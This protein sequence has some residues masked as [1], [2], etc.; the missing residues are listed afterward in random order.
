MPLKLAKYPLG[1]LMLYREDR[2]CGRLRS[3]DADANV[4]RIIRMNGMC[5]HSE[6]GWDVTAFSCLLYLLN[7]SN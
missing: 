5:L 6:D 3:P 4:Y 2:E 7:L 1:N